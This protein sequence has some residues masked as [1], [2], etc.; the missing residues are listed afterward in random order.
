L[1]SRNDSTTLTV[2][3][4]WSVLPDLT[5]EFVI[6]EPSWRFA[7]VSSGSPAQFEIAY[8]AGTV[9]QISGRAAN[10][11]NQEGSPDLCPLTRLA[12]GQG[13]ADFGVPAIP[14]FSLDAPGG[15]NLVLSQVGFNSLANIASVSSGTLQLFY[16]NELADPSSYRLDTALD[17]STAVI[18]VNSLPAVQAGDFIQVSTEVM[19]VIS[20]DALAKKLSVVRGACGSPAM[21]HAVGEA[22][23]KLD[24]KV[25]VVPF[26]S[27]FF[28]NRASVNFLHTFRLPDAR[29]STA[30]FFVTNA[31]GN[32]Q[33]QQVCFTQNDNAGLRTLSGGQFSLQVS[34]YLATQQN[35]TP[36]LVI[37][38][39]HA[40]RDVRA[41]LNQTAL[42]YDTVI[43]LLQ[44]GVEYC[45]LVVPSSSSNSDLLNGIK[46]PPLQAEAAITMNVSL[47][48][49]G[50]AVGPLS[51]GRDLTVTIR[52]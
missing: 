5:S 29:V 22:V 28:E 51:P 10:V 36:P 39:S 30:E 41:S 19:S 12:L 43:H 13:Q 35:A 48:P 25:I 33:V 23:L 38:S 16:W 32:S 9:I 52:L 20:I 42:G 45:S 26:A 46:L 14:A 3:S 34:G 37:E 27:G 1:I 15:G 11:Y 17:T 2:T 8:Q 49:A 31:F 21:R 44:N 47:K 50:A 6:C 4:P 24:T 40:V 7:A 18:Q